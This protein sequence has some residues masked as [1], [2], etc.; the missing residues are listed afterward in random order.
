MPAELVH[1]I[2]DLKEV[3]AKIDK[4]YIDPSKVKDNNLLQLNLEQG[5]RLLLKDNLSKDLNKSI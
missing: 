2:G 3:Y 1:K 4:Q 5:M